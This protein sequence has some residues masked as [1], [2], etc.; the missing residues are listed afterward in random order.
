LVTEAD[1]PFISAANPSAFLG[2]DY[3]SPQQSSLGG[4]GSFSPLE[5]EHA[6]F[7]AG[8]G[9]GASLV[10]STRGLDTGV[11]R[12]VSGVLRVSRGGAWD[13]VEDD[14]TVSGSGLG[15]AKEEARNIEVLYHVAQDGSVRVFE[16]GG[17]DVG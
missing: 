9:H 11:A 15:S 12:D 3:L 17:G 1:T 7:V 13:E 6:S 4:V 5:K 2:S 10:V 14:E 16:R 8:Q